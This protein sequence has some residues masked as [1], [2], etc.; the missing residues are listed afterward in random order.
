LVAAFCT[1]DDVRH[2]SADA[3]TNYLIQAGVRRPHAASMVH[4]AVTAA[5]AQ[6][7][8]LP[9]EATT[10]TLVK[11]LAR[12]LLD[13]DRDLKD[14]DKLIADRFHDHPHAAIIESLPGIGPILGAEFVVATGGNISGFASSGRLASSRRPSTRA[15]GLR[16]RDR[17][18]APPQ[19]L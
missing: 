19:A 1:P 12:Q 15:S 16:P 14:T 7:V 8:Q 9:G 10:A 4:S 5:Q 13:L 6:T 11:R 3:L 17:Q 2:T 18:P